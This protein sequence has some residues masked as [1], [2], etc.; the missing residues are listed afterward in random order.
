MPHKVVEFLYPM[1]FS[2]L[3]HSDDETHDRIIAFTSQMAHVVSNNYCKSETGAEHRGYSADSL[4]DLTRVAGL[5]PAMWSELFIA[6]KDYLLLEV[7]RLIGDMQRMA[8]AI[9]R[10]DKGLLERMLLEGSDA[11]HVLYPREGVCERSA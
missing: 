1:G 3:V 11:K 2:E 7:E 8:D 4:R 9:R 5:N 6:N 10:E